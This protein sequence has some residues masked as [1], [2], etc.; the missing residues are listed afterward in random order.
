VRAVLRTTVQLADA[1]RK[2]FDSA[3]EFVKDG[4]AVFWTCPHDAAADVVFEDEEPGGAQSGDD[5]RHLS[6]DI[7]AILVIFD[8][9][10][11]APHLP[12]DPAQ[13]GEDLGLVV[14]VRGVR[15]HWVVR[16][17]LGRKLIV[18]GGG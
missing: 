8:H 5:R 4:F 12:L 3:R 14:G 13:A 10:A 9:P 15:S 1:T 16:R 7:D 11:D 6:E 2:A 17:N 18:V